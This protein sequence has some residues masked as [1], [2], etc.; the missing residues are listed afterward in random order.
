MYIKVKKKWQLVID[1]LMI[2]IGT[3]LMGFAFSIFLE[4]NNISTGGF[5][6]LAMVISALLNKIGITFL[7]TSIIYFVLNIGLFLYAFKTLGKKFAIKS[8]A[9]IAFFSLAMELCNLIPINVTYEPL[10]SAIYGGILMGAG[11][12]IVVRFGGSTGGGDMI[13][14]IVRSKRPKFSIGTIVIMIDAIVIVLSLFVFNNG[15]EILP[16]TIIALAICSVCTDLVNDGYKQVRA[17]HVI[18]KNADKIGSRV[19]KEL[20][21]GCTVSRAEGMYSQEQRDH[22]ICLI[23]KFQSATLIRII[24]E[25]DPEA[26]VFST[27]V[28]EVEGL[29]SKTEE[30]NEEIAKSE[31]EKKKQKIADKDKIKKASENSEVTNNINTE[32]EIIE[33]GTDESNKSGKSN[34]VKKSNKKDKN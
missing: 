25:E 1:F 26:F 17:Y 3:V 2:L 9:G 18:T 22:L 32:N 15:S 13:A 19:M 6:G 28:C 11:I 33:N 16:Y 23:S 21:R 10:L 20:F 4:P 8:L 14:S 34:T 27:K 5:S 31:L 12:G 30:I 29:W 24:K 7:N